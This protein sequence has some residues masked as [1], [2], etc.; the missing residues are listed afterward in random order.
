MSLPDS[1][2]HVEQLSLLHIP[3]GSFDTLGLK[4]RLWLYCSFRKLWASRGN[5]FYD[6]MNKLI[7]IIAFTLVN[8]S[9]NAQVIYVNSQ[10]SGLNNGTSWENAYTSLREALQSAAYGDEIWVARGNYNA[11][12]KDSS[13]SFRPKSGVKLF[14]GFIGTETQRE[15]RDWESNT[16]ELVNY[17]GTFALPNV[18][19]YEHTDSTTRIDGFVIKEGVSFLVGTDDCNYGGGTNEF[20][21]HGGGLYAY[22]DDTTKPTC[23]TIANCSFYKNVAR[24]GGGVSLNFSG[25]AGSV[26]IL[27]CQFIENA[28]NIEGGGIYAYLG[29]VGT[30]KL[31]IDQCVFE[32]NGALAAAAIDIYNFNPNTK[33]TIKN[34]EFTNNKSILSGAVFLGNYSKQI[35]RV[36]N[37]EFLSNIAG[38]N[39]FEPGRGGGLVAGNTNLDRCSFIGNKA[40]EG[41]AAEV[42]NGRITNCLI[43]D[44]YSTSQGGAIKTLGKNH[45]INSTFV[46]NF[47]TNYGGAFYSE[48]SSNA[49]DTI[50]NCLFWNNR[51]ALGGD[52]IA[53]QEM[54]SLFHL[55]VDYS[56]VD[57]DNCAQITAPIN[58]NAGDAFD[59][60]SHMLW[61]AYPMFRDSALKDFR[62]LAGSPA[63]NAG[64]SSIIAQL[65]LLVD[66]ENN[67]RI[68]N[69]LPD[70]GAYEYQ[71]VIPV[72]DN[73]KPAFAALLSPNPIVS[74][75]HPM[76]QFE[77]PLV[78]SLEVS[79]LGI[80]GCIIHREIVRPNAASSAITLPVS[81]TPGIYLIRISE[82]LKSGRQ[83]T[84]KLIVMH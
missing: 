27:N 6:L 44:N 8:I 50:L 14:G 75:V 28:G 5:L 15:Q 64:D 34:S 41:A 20:V 65:E 23:L 66:L 10:S 48:H 33:I 11:Y 16:T 57:A 42:F 74:G 49:P 54:F 25:G 67:P 56:L 4:S 12:V 2:G 26:S 72:Y 22:S 60:G 17:A 30:N 9:G 79:I 78:N 76:I 7:F 61:N 13:F 69:G 37:C 73:E 84:L 63:I 68:G 35:A 45:I 71:G 43:A 31:E 51:A 32:K 81:L 19:Y 38:I 83:V 36:E 77:E 21:C 46:N 3:R 52:F 47:C 59:C 1:T 58:L 18:V 82:Q 39:N 80:D 24:F 40:Y 70:L 62:L 53:D 29:N 55:Y